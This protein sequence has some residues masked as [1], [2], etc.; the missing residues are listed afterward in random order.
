MPHSYINTLVTVMTNVPQ[1]NEPDTDH[2]QCK[3]PVRLFL[4]ENIKPD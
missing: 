4:T 3:Y 2:S 1:L